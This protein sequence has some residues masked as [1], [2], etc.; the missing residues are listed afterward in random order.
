MGYMTGL[1]NSLFFSQ[2]RFSKEPAR[3]SH[4]RAR[5]KKKRLS[6]FHTLRACFERRA[7]AMQSWF[8]C[9]SLDCS[10]TL[11][12]LGFRRRIYFSRIER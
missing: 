9:S 2:N 10:T 5:K 6:V 4:A 11:A 1:Q 3:A 7:T 8:D 12:R